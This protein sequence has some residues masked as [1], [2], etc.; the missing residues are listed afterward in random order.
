MRGLWGTAFVI[1]ASLAL[2]Q[3]RV[4]IPEEVH[5]RGEWITLGEIA[6]ISGDDGGLRDISLGRAP[7]PGSYRDL[8]CAF[9]E[10]R[11]GERAELSCPERVRVWR[12][13]QRVPQERIREV[14]LEHLGKRF[15]RAQ[16]IAL[17]DFKV[18]GDVVLPQGPIE[19]LVFEN[20][21]DLLGRTS[22]SVLLRAGC[23]ERK[24]LVSCEVKVW[25]VVPLASRRIPRGEIL[26]PQDLT[27]RTMELSGLPRGVVLDPQAL[28]GKR[29]K[30]SLSLG[31]PFR[32]DQVEVPP[33]VKRGDR[34]RIVVMTQNLRIQALGE[35]L[36]EGRIGDTVRVRNLGSGREVVAEV[37]DGSTLVVRAF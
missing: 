33:V 27:L 6:I 20:S 17:E 37:L 1:L 2:A 8:R 31:S 14:I 25:A 30:T 23:M 29:T 3:P 7:L 18:S 11:I 12:S 9:I 36:E 32:W 26:S 10:A 34:V 13:S 22:F 28:V 35:V 15:P 24:V 16:K 21:R 5:V 19:A 4:T